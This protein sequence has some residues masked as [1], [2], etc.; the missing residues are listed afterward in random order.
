MLVNNNG[1]KD[2]KK[3]GINNGNSNLLA[4]YFDVLKG[5]SI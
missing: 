5:F 2:T 4:E 1:F 3:N